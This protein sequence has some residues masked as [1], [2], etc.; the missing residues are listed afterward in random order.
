M[1]TIGR[2]S[3]RRAARSPI[4]KWMDCA[5]FS[6]PTPPSVER[7]RVRRGRDNHLRIF[8]APPAF[9][10]NQLAQLP[11]VCVGNWLGKGYAKR[12]GEEAEILNVPLPLD[13]SPARPLTTN[14]HTTSPSSLPSPFLRPLHSTDRPSKERPLPLLPEFLNHCRKEGKKEIRLGRTCPLALEVC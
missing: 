2:P 10:M 5:I 9:M 14:N 8:P 3:L 6:R 4:F 13:C 7:F 11:A 12:R 1:R